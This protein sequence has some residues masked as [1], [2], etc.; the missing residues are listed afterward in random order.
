MQNASEGGVYPKG[1]GDMIAI[2]TG[3]RKVT[4]KCVNCYVTNVRVG[5][6]HF[7]VFFT[8]SCS[9]EGSFVSP[10]THYYRDS[11]KTDRTHKGRNY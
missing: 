4:S 8:S 10:I 5:S 1:E 7:A 11:V 6:K 2:N 3:K 9:K